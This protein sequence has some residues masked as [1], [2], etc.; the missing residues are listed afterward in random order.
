MDC[1]LCRGKGRS[2]GC[3]YCGKDIIVIKVVGFIGNV[4]AG[5]TTAANYLVSKGY[6]K[7]RFAEALKK[8]MIDGLGIDKE[9]VDGSKKNEPCEELCGVTCRIGMI[10]LGTEWG[11]HLIHPDLWVVRLSRELCRLI[12]LGECK[13]VIDDFR[14]LNEVQWLRRLSVSSVAP[15][16]SCLIRIEREKSEIINHQSETEQKG[17]EVDFTIDNTRSL[18][19]LHKTIDVAIEHLFKKE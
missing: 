19:L 7:I 10:T 15:I 11:R 18:D 14:F 4:G 12:A 2:N 3:P 13:F 6:I 5:K 16:E 1:T 9:Y 8:M 17:V